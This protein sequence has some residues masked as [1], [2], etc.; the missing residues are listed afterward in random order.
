MY[1]KRVDSLVSSFESSL[2]QQGLTLEQYLQYT[3]MTMDSIRETYLERA[4]GEVKLRLALEAIV[5]AENIEVTEA[6]IDDG[7]SEIAKAYNMELDQIKRLMPM[8]DYKMDLLVTKALDLV[9][10]NAVVDN[11]VAEKSE[12]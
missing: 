4:T 1:E 6:E 10:E 7:L 11:S 2:K 8:D 12:D 3:G 9:K 5:K